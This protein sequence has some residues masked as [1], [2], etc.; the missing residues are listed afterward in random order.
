[1]AKINLLPWRAERRKQREREFQSMLGGAL[2]VGLIAVFVAIFHWDGL[3][4]DQTQ[5][6]QLLE[7]EITALDAKIKE[8]EAL[9]QT[10][11]QLGPA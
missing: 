6:N 5:R 11:E 4:E 10:R 9:Q 2:I 3:K 7:R 1:M 8:I